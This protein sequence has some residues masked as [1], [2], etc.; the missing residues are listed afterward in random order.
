MPA[1]FDLLP[2]ILA[3]LDITLKVTAG[4]IALAIVMSFLAGLAKISRFFPLRWLAIA[5]IET[6]RGTSAL[7]QLFWFFYVLPFMGFDLSALAAG[8]IVLG[9]NAGSYGAE[10][11]RGAIQSVPKG[12]YEAATALNMGR[13]RVLWRIIV[14][15]AIPSM[16]PP[17]GNIFIELLKNTALVA[18][19][20]L[21]DLTYEARMIWEETS[22]SFEVF[23]L[24]LFVYFALALCITFVMR[25]LEKFFSRSIDRRRA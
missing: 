17:F 3:G 16:L 5:Y 2:S 4:G 15:Q 19:I 18:L 11:V 21:A 12:Q 7:V 14:P 22:R 9:L 25:L 10:V 6:F 20:T 24:L 1:P 13:Y 23:A 8:I